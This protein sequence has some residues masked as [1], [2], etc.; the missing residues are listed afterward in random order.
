MVEVPAGND[1][2]L[3]ELNR[4][5][6]E[7]RRTVDGMPTRIEMTSEIRNLRTELDSKI[8]TISSEQTGMKQRSGIDRALQYA[9]LLA[10]IGQMALLVWK[11]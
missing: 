9:I 11:Q 5:L 10:F 7:L 6:G 4:N 1:V 3:G 2:T 8:T